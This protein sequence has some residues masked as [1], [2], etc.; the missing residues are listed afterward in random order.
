MFRSL[1]CVI[2][3]LVRKMAG[4]DM[5]SLADVSFYHK[6]PQKYPWLA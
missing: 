2:Q 1:E 5:H 4:K 3:L 6:E